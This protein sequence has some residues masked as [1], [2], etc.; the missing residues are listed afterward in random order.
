MEQMVAIESRSSGQIIDQLKSRLAAA[1]HCQGN[2]AVQRH[3]RRGLQPLKKA[4]KF[5]DLGPISILR[6]VSRDSAGPRWQPG[7]R[8][9]L[10]RPETLL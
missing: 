7:R 4:V 3:D 2:G 6:R 9:A 8:K 10:D 5:E 1:Y